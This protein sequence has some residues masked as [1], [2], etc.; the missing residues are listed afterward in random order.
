MIPF[1]IIWTKYEFNKLLFLFP[2][3][4][5]SFG[6]IWAERVRRNKNLDNYRSSKLMETPDITET[7][8]KENKDSN[9]TQ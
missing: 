7:W 6:I 5:L 8:E 3:F 2:L 9:L 1:F 4:G